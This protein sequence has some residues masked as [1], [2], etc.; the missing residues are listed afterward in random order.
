LAEFA[1]KSFKKCFWAGFAA[2]IFATGASAQT[3]GSSGTTGGS[4][5]SSSLNTN[6][7]GGGA[8]NAAGSGTAITIAPPSQVQTSNSMSSSNIIGQYYANPMYQGRSGTAGSSTTSITNPGG[9]NTALYGSGGTGG[10]GSRSS[11][12]GGGAAPSGVGG[13]GGFAGS[14]GTTGGTGA[15]GFG[16]ATGAGGIGGTSGAT[17][18]F[19][20]GTTGRTAGGTGGFGATGGAGG[21]GN[22]RGLG[23]TSGN[24]QQNNGLT[25]P[26]PIAYTATYKFPVP[27]VNPL[28]QQDELRTLIDNSSQLIAPKDV[29]LQTQA[30]GIVVLKGQVADEDEA[31][32]VEGLLR[33][34]PGV[35]DVINE[36]TFPKTP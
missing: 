6:F 14:T 7:G 36:L 1:M 20:G 8:G 17:G 25:S 24:N 12:G 33:I 27:V 15:T 30:G 13:T 18:G 19:G 2:S 5:G 4:L 31:R 35:R 3:D 32:L 11:G 10:I 28:M 9:F 16:G 26:R 23:G 34:T 29:K 22:T 21:L